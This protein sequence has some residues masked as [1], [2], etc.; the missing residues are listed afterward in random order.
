MPSPPSRKS[1]PPRPKEAIVEVVA[2]DS[3]RQPVASPADRSTGQCQVLDIEPSAEVQAG[4]DRALDRID[5]CARKLGDDIGDVVDDIGVITGLAMHVVGTG[6]AVEGIVAESAKQEI[7]PTEAKKDRRRHR[8]RRLADR[9]RKR[10]RARHHRDLLQRRL[11]ADQA[12]TIAVND[13]SEAPTNTVPGAQTATEDTAKIFNSGNGSQISISDVDE[14]SHTVTLITTNG[15]ITLNG[16]SGLSFTVGD[17]TSDGTMT[18]SGTDASIN[19]ALN[20]LRFLGATNFNG[21][22]SIRIVTTDGVLSDTDLVAITVNAVNDVPV[23]SSLAITSTSIS[24]VAT[25]PDKANLSLTSAFAA[26]FGNPTV[27]SAKTTVLTPTEQTS[28]VVGSPEHTPSDGRQ[29]H[30]G[31]RQPL[32]R[33]RLWHSNGRGG[34][35][36]TVMYGFGG[37]DE[38]QRRIRCR[39][40]VWWI[41]KIGAQND[42]VLDGGTET[43]TLQVAAN[44]T[45]TGN[46]QIV[47]TENVLLTVGVTL[48][49]S[50]QTEGFAITGSSGVDRVRAVP[51][52]IRFQSTPAPASSPSSTARRSTAKATLEVQSIE[53]AIFSG[54]ACLWR[55]PTIGGPG[56]RE[57][58]HLR[59]RPLRSRH[60]RFDQ[61]FVPGRSI[62]VAPEC[63]FSIGYS[64]CLSG[65][66][67]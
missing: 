49:L 41:R 60:C 8:L 43:D 32:P 7:V 62:F 11:D 48:N 47:N 38:S 19:A 20:G 18:F 45:S 10:R 51:E 59:V 61:L 57:A 3:V 31:R 52:R 1:F 46:V 44:F 25:D 17:G 26:A 37:N 35:V 6:A 56:A 36:D 4:A 27:I 22:A 29:R 53:R 12:F 13:I 30:G 40:A 64:I 14:T 67:H 2:D 5:A 34:A 65:T 39:L 42:R 55:S 63:A 54:F 50:K 23:I 66:A 24:F 16:T 33:H 9:P 21:A 15:A 28:G 58:H